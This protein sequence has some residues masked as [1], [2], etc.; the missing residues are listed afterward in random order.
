VPADTIGAM[1]CP[2]H[3]TPDYGADRALIE[4]GSRTLQAARILAFPLSTNVWPL[5]LF[6]SQKVFVLPGLLLVGFGDATYRRDM[7]SAIGLSVVGLLV[8]FSQ[9]GNGYDQSHLLGYISFVFAM[10]LIN[11]AAR[12]D[13]TLLRR[14]LTYITLF[15]V[16]MSIYLLVYN[17]DLYGF[18]GLNRIEGTDG[19]TYRVYFEASSLAAVFLLRSFRNR[20]LQLATLAAVFF[21]VVF[22]ARSAVVMALL[23]LNL[24]APY[25]LRSAPH[26]RV[27][28]GIVAI[29]IAVLLYIYLPVIRPD[30]DLSLRAKQLQ[31]QVILSL[32]PDNWSGWGWGA[33][34]PYLATDRE[35]PY[36]IEMQLPML[37]LQLGPLALAAILLLILGL[38]M[39]AAEQ[40]LRGY[41][42]FVIYALIGFNNPWLLVPS[43][44]LTCQLMFRDDHRPYQLP[45][46]PDAASESS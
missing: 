29:A 27:A 13:A 5:L 20:W 22:V 8:Y 9:F 45:E 14:L 32:L 23:G 28:A 15:N 1:P 10:P 38:F 3:V 6:V 11:Y 19:V 30:I 21:F 12:Y 33:Y 18:R 2:D 39:S 43:W 37:M 16:A 26:I 17:I 46:P 41:V 24:V 42:R 25:I 36:Q 35:Q 7:V 40:S 31:L 34:L 4:T 44:Y